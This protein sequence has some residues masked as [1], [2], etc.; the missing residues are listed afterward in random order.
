MN[1]GFVV[2]IKVLARGWGRII[3][4]ADPD[5]F[6]RDCFQVGIVV[7]LFGGLSG[8]AWRNQRLGRFL[9]GELLNGIN[10]GSP[11]SNEDSDARGGYVYRNGQ[12]WKGPHHDIGRIVL[13]LVVVVVVVCNRSSNHSRCSRV[14]SIVGAADVVVRIL[15]VAAVVVGRWH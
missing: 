14:G 5:G 9:G 1:V 12:V 8:T 11:F 6:G 10:V 4:D 15:H 2:L 3:D 7:V 13:L